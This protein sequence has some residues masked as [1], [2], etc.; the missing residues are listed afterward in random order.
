MGSFYAILSIYGFLR[1]QMGKMITFFQ[2]GK[3]NLGVH[4]DD[5]SRVCVSTASV[6]IKIFC[7]PRSTLEGNFN[8]REKGKE[9][10]KKMCTF[11]L[12]KSLF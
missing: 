12:P 8:K 9:K 10:G 4:T 1:C 11:F 5:S 7:E 6:I 3:K 2:S